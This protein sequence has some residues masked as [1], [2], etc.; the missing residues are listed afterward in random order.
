MREVAQ[1]R[2]V[3]RAALDGDLL[4]GGLG[5]DDDLGDVARVAGQGDQRGALVDGEV[6]GPAGDVEAGVTGREDA[7]PGVA[8]G[9]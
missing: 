6:P 8:W 7:R 1:R 4:A 5:A 3:V 9:V 2:R